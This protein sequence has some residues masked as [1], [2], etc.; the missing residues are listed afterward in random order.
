MYTASLIQSSLIII[1]GLNMDYLK[2]TE[3]VPH[4]YLTCI[5]AI[6]LLILI[7]RVDQEWDLRVSRLRLQC[8]AVLMHN[9]QEVRILLLEELVNSTRSCR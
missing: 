8:M 9:N 5:E 4:Q 1:T 7:I 2:A 3:S 6:K